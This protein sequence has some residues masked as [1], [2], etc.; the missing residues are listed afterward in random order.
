MPGPSL[1]LSITSVASRPAC[2]SVGWWGARS[3]CEYCLAASTSAE[4]RWVLSAISASSVSV[5][6]V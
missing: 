4:T 3:I 6:T 1:A 2:R 5:S